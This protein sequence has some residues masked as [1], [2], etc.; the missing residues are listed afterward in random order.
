MAEQDQKERRVGGEATISSRSNEADQAD[1]VDIPRDLRR[2]P[3]RNSVLGSDNSN[4]RLVTTADERNEEADAG[5]NVVRLPDFY[6]NPSGVVSAIRAGRI[7]KREL[8]KKAA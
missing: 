6:L 8:R 1:H 2:L 5:S 7:E 3:A 4:P